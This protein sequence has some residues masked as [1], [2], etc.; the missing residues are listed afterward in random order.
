MVEDE[1]AA[2]G[3]EGF[4][5]GVGCGEGAAVDL[6]GDGYVGVEVEGAGGPLGVFEDDVSEVRGSIRKRWLGE[7][8]PG[9]LAAGFEA[10]EDF[11]V[12]AEID[13]A[14]VDLARC[15][16]LFGRETGGGVGALALGDDWIE[17]AGDGI[18]ND[19][20]LDGVGCVAGF[21]GG[22]VKK[23]IT[24]SGWPIAQDASVPDPACPAL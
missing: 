13:R 11:F 7:G 23:S 16:D 18:P 4:E 10:G 3:E 8:I 21:E 14:S 12:G 5:V 24:F 19:A 15:F 2:V 1:L 20:I 22:L 9:D 17:V 6:L